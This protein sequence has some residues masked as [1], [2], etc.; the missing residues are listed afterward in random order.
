MQY[1]C[2]KTSA[3]EIVFGEGVVDLQML[4]DVGGSPAGLLNNTVKPQCFYLLCMLLCSL[5]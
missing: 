3:M 5:V 1:Y 2:I 4:I